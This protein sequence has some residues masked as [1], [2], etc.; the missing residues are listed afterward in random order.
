M[1]KRRQSGDEGGGSSAM[2]IMTALIGCLILI[3]LGILVIVLVSQVLI[4][5]VSPDDKEVRTMVDSNVAGFPESRAFPKGNTHKEPL[6]IDVHPNHL[7]LIGYDRTVQAREIYFPDNDYDTALDTV[8]SRA[9]LEYVLFLVR[10]GATELYRSLLE[11]IDYHNST[12]KQELRVQ[13]GMELFEAGREVK[14]EEALREQREDLQYMDLDDF[15]RE[16]KSRSQMEKNTQ[17]APQAPTGGSPVV[18]KGN[19]VVAPGAVESEPGG[20]L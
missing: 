4:A 1:G 5:I 6:Y 2:D 9:D 15:R 13:Y 18:N 3:L 14:I 17:S 7:V 16:Q 11:K 19:E 10:P 12:S 8:S 20:D